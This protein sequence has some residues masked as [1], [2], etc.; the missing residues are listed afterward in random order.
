MGEGSAGVFGFEVTEALLSGVGDGG[1]H[2]VAHETAR[3][4]GAPDGEMPDEGCLVL[5]AARADAELRALTLDVGR[6]NGWRG[7][8]EEVAGEVDGAVPEVVVRYIAVLALFGDSPRPGFG[9]GPRFRREGGGRR[10]CPERIVR[11]V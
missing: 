5:A 6:I 7:L 4:L 2:D 8:V 9:V 10:R 1:T 3:D 11:V